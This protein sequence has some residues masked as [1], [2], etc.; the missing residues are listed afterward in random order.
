MN[1]LEKS[2]YNIINHYSKIFEKQSFTITVPQKELYSYTITLEKNKQKVKLLVYFGKKG[3]KIQV[4]GN[5]ESSVHKEVNNIVFGEKLFLD[6]DK[7]F[8]EPLVYIGTDESGKGDLFGPLVVAGV[9]VDE[10]INLDLNKLGVRDSKTITDYNIKKLTPKIKTLLKNK[11]DIIHLKPEKYNELYEK[12]SNVNLILGWA[13]AKV[14]ENILESY[15]VEEAISDKFGNERTILNALQKK[16]RQINLR[17]VTNAE[18]YTAVAAASIIARNEVINWFD[19]NSR[20]FRIKIYKGVSA[21][22]ENSMNEVVEKFGKEVLP[23]FVKMHFKTT[24][25][26]SLKN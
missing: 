11:Y 16:G 1:S 22:V 19:T 8:A 14:I 10:K 24:K 21:Q 20:K 23:K 6:E 2:A 7:M 26:L 25:K 9:L 13:H 18:R 12:M 5:Q 4:Q 15:K 3:N 17:Q